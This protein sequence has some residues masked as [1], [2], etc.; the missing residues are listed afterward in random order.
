MEPHDDELSEAG[1]TEVCG[2]EWND[3]QLMDAARPGKMINA[4]EA[5]IC[6]SEANEYAR[7]IKNKGCLVIWDIEFCSTVFKDAWKCIPKY[8]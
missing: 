8:H 6:N 7:K 3:E 4:S 2:R 1:W 5:N